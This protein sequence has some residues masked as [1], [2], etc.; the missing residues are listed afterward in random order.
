M[1][2]G[3]QANNIFN[4]AFND[5]YRI[6]SFIFIPHIKRKKFISSGIYLHN[7]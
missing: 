6:W 2:S 1:M 7:I 5:E 4:V 3:D